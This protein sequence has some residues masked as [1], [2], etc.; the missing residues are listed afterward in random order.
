MADVSHPV[1]PHGTAS[2]NRLLR[3]VDS[4]LLPGALEVVE[5]AAG[6]VLCR[7]DEAAAFAYFI[8]DGLVTLTAASTEGQTVEVATIGREGLAGAV[9]CLGMRAL[10]FETRV[11]VAGLA[12]RID[13]ELLCEELGH[14]ATSL[15]RMVLKYL[16]YEFCQVTQAALCSRFHSSEQRVAKWLLVARER[17]DVPT[18]PL[19]HEGIAQLV[20]GPRHEVTRDLT[21]LEQAGAVQRSRGSLTIVDTTIL[22]ARACECHI[23]IRQA[24]ERLV[25]PSLP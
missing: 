5:L 15:T 13:A 3:S 10:P 23:R 4:S 16:Q 2:R 19:T 18:L 12:R 24:L 1:R 17:L 25:A 22:Q 14:H 11:Q 21:K 9:A 20:G 7:P 8:E 6:D